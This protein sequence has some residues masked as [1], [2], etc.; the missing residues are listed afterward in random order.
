MVNNTVYICMSDVV[1]AMHPYV[2]YDISVSWRLT[3][4]NS[5]A[6]KAVIQQILCY[7]SNVHVIAKILSITGQACS[8]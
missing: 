2:I 3:A 7:Q 5:Y 1:Y 4:A 8:Q 6:K